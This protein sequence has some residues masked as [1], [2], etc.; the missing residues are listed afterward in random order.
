MKTYVITG[1]TSG[2]GKALCEYFAKDNLVFAGYRNPS[3]KDDLEQ[4]SENVIPFYVDYSKPDTINQA[5]E[6]IKSKT[7]KIDT[8][9][10]VAGGVVA[11]AIEELDISELRR[12][13][14]INVFGAVQLTQ[15]LVNLL[16]NGKVINIS[17][18]S[19]YGIYPFIAPYC[20][21]KRALDILFNC[22]GLETKRNIKVVSIKPGVIA[23]PLWTKSLKEN[24]KTIEK[25]TKD[26]SGEIN[27]MANNARENEK[28]GLPVNVV[29]EKI[30]KIDKLS[31]PKPSYCIGVDSVA[32]AIVSRLPQCI[33]NKIIKLKLKKIR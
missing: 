4:Y 30:A 29:V 14:D 10:N 20:A 7:E 1:A 33:L 2:I 11:G 19:S 13:F 8:L 17:S 5:I 9:L 16:E 23:T 26:F 25:C 31:N 6:F 3:K 15:G 32:T 18:M 28:N 21:S 27:Y 22:F 24:E 12:Q